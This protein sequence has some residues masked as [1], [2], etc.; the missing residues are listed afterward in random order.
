MYQGSS[1]GAIRTERIRTI[2]PI[3]DVRERA[4]NS[5]LHNR[6]GADKRRRARAT[7]RPPRRVQVRREQARA[8][9]RARGERRALLPRQLQQRSRAPRRRLE[10]AQDVRVHL[11]IELVFRRAPAQ[12]TQLILR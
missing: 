11:A 2:N 9:V 5:L 1:I 10:H 8:S 3:D 7:R 4:V 6:H 12:F